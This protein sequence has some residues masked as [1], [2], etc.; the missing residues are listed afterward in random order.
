MIHPSNYVV[1]HSVIYIDQKRPKHNIY[2]VE[3]RIFSQFR[4]I[5]M[6]IP[7]YKRLNTDIAQSPLLSPTSRHHI[8]IIPM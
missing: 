4:K 3:D 1:R 6:R 5:D 7:T 8:V 2:I